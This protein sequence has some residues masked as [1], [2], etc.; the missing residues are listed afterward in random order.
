MTLKHRFTTAL[1][2]LET[3]KSRSLLTILG[4]VIGITAIILV[5]SV[6]KGAEE[7][8]LNQIRGLGAKTIIIEPG[9]EP[10]GPSDFAE[11]FTDSI[12]K[13]DAESLQNPSKVRGVLR[14]APLV[15]QVSEVS[16][17]NELIRTSVQGISSE[18]VDILG[19][20]PEK[21]VFFND[22]DVKERSSAAVIGSETKRKLFGESEALDQKIKIKNRTFRVIGI[23]SPQG[24][25][26]A[27]DI[28][29]IVLVPYTT[30]QEYLFGI[31]HF[32]A[33]I[34]EAESEEAVPRVAEE[35]KITLRE[36]HGIAD[37][38]KDDFHVTT[39]EDIVKRIGVVAS[40][41]TILLVSIAAISLV[42]GGIGVMNIMLVSVTERTR[43]IGLRKALGATEKDILLQFLFESMILTAVGGI[44]GIILGAL[45]SFITSLILSRII[46]LGWIYVFSATA[47][48]LGLGVS[49]LIGLIFGL[50]PARRAASKN[51]IEALRYE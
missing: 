6:G 29:N 1:K 23:F 36:N 24:R 47:A 5:M 17:E 3:Q 15:L 28:D 22:D 42:V 50:Y 21:G 14:V 37:P 44:I 25:I 18:I 32:N 8:I 45:F 4:I 13:K 43:E 46:S 39:Q 33:I 31:S 9:R 51:P 10:T 30:A 48:I 40:I 2:G 20:Y 26:G 7:L 34:A 16:F 27:L 49:G 11:I 35:I 41:L 38:E 12:K 19:I